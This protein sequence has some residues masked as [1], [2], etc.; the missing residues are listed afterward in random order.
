MTVRQSL[1]R[2]EGTGMDRKKRRNMLLLAAGI[3]MAVSVLL[4][5]L[6]LVW[7]SKEYRAVQAIIENL[8]VYQEEFESWGYQVHVFDPV[9]DP[10][11]ETDN[12]ELLPH[13]LR[14]YAERNYHPVLILTDQTGGNWFFCHG[15]DQYA[16][17]ATS[18][19]LRRV[20]EDEEKLVEITTMLWLQKDKAKRI[21][22]DFNDAKRGKRAYYDMV[23]QL[24]ICG[25]SPETD[26]EVDIWDRGFADTQYCS[27][28]FEEFKGFSGAETVS[29]SHRANGIIK[30]RYTAEQLLEIYW[31][32]IALQNQLIELSHRE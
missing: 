6:K 26:E 7:S 16:H 14:Y 21:P 1:E 8:P 24:Y 28:N 19:E 17:E 18:Q 13:A 5:I 32:G 2:M 10:C 4:L 12:V 11:E 31:Q 30:E 9:K 25:V 20:D 29:A 3:G 27:N 15:F 22:S 23:I